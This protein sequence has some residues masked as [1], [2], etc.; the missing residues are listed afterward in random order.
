MIS[1]S[2]WL[3]SLL[4][5]LIPSF[6]CLIFVLFNLLFDRSLL[7]ALNNHVIIIILIIDLITEL[8]TYPWMIYF[9]YNDGVWD[10]RSMIFC[11][12]W[13]FI[14]WGLFL[15]H[16]ILF[17]WTTVERHILI[18]HE[19]WASTRMRRL[20]VHYFPLIILLLYN[21]IFN[22]VLDFFPPCENAFIDDIAVC[23]SSCLYD[24]DALSMYDTIA[25]QLVPIFTIILFSTTLLARVI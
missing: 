13:T 20:L 25:H 15:T 10:G 5:S 23:A 17:A 14:D 1:N 21:L 2:I 4:L 9:Y 11:E 7:H 19:K 16:T 12:I 6:F 24:I 3:W 18:F 8:T 22:I